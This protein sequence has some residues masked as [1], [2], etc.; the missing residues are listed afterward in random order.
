D[1]VKIG[2][3]LQPGGHFEPVDATPIDAARREVEEE[4]GISKL[5][6]LG[7][8]DVDIHDIDGRQ[9]HPAHAHFDLRFLFTTEQRD[10]QALDGVAG[11]KWVGVHDKVERLGSTVQR[12]LDKVAGRSERG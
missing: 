6:T 2:K 1:H 7:L 3:W 11:A 9:D 10:L 12:L 4:C 5:E 8:I